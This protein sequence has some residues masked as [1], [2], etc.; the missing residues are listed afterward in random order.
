MDA[1][2]WLALVA[3][4]ALALVATLIDGVGRLG[5]RRRGRGRRSPERRPERPSDPPPD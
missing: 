2:W 4:A 5:P 3:V 1:L